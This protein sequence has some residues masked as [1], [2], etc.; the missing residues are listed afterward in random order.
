MYMGCALLVSLRQAVRVHTRAFHVG[1]TVLSYDPSSPQAFAV[2]NHFNHSRGV[3]WASVTLLTLTTPESHHPSFAAEVRYPRSTCIV[4]MYGRQNK[5]P[6]RVSLVYVVLRRPSR[7][8]MRTP[9]SLHKLSANEI[10]EGVTE[11][12]N[13]H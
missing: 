12:Q 11:Y 2:T 3:R 1:K 4:N 5:A 9:A 8:R 6:G 7:P 10:R 13:A